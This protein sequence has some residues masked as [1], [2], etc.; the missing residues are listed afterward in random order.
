MP[1]SRR[2]ACVAFIALT[3]CLA[4]LADAV[5]A[6]PVTGRPIAELLRDAAG[7]GLRIVFSDELVP[8][9]LLAVSEPVSTETVA[10]LREILRPHALT[11]LEVSPGT[12]VVTRERQEPRTNAARP[13]P[14]T[15]A[16]LEEVHVISSRFTLEA[17]R[18][19]DAFV[20]NPVDLEQQPALFD[21]PVRGVRRF[22]GTAGSGLSSRSFVRGGTPDENLLLLDGVAL[23]DPFHLPGLPADFSV[24]DP[25]VLGRVDFYSGVLPV[26][27]GDRASSVIDMRS[28]MSADEFAGR[29]A[30]STLNVSTLAEG[31][32]PGARGDW[33]AFARRGTVDLVAG[34]L[35]PDFG[36]PV[37]TDALGRIRYRLTSES[38]LTLGGLGADDDLRLSMRDGAEVTS[39]DSDRGYS[40]VALDQQFGAATARTLLT[41]TSS[42]VN[43][44]GDLDDPVGSTGGVRDQR[45]LQVSVLKQ[46]WTTPLTPDRAL[47]W[48]AS[49]RRDRA[50]YDY[51]RM[52][53]FPAEIAALFDRP[54]VSQYAVT[55][56]ASLRQYAAYAGMSET[57]S[58]RWRVDGGVRWTLAEYSTGQEESAWDPRIGLM[59]HYSP[60]TRLRLSWGKMTQIWGA[61]EVPVE[62]DQALF[63][64]SSPSYMSVLGWEHDFSSGTT[65]RA[66]LYDKRVR[67]PRPRLENMLDPVVLVPEL[68]PDEVLIE[69]DWSRVTGLD[70]HATAALGR[71]SNG[72]LSYSW[73]HARDVIDGREVARSWDQRHAL[74]LGVATE[75][76]GWQ[77]SSLLTLRTDWPLTPVFE[78][79][80]PPGVTI[81][82][83]NS[84][85]DGFFMTLDLKAE[86]TF[87]LAIGSLHVAAELTNALDRQNFCCTE[88]EFE[89]APDG[90]L[91]AEESRKYWLPTV[92]YV[93]VAWEF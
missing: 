87:R 49:I 51:A 61:D 2:P 45:R 53:S 85:R 57:L 21:D 13:I 80:S 32:L 14:R 11:L 40:W 92:P 54:P 56:A 8:Q 38:T 9:D 79:S 31:P 62:R 43:R 37:L 82:E 25:V 52:T 86:R 5:A 10:Q 39:I 88:L 75:R 83:R 42:S 63:D 74:A 41:H 58:S 50:E 6:V 3:L 66:E 26:E 72:W 30:L 81:G 73:S 18:A 64:R 91:T 90:A 35:E 20:L 27:Y 1:T 36:R 93:S 33:L 89:T 78:S 77:F 24:I 23:H 12:Y 44:S 47:R 59:Y 34:A 17:Q 76:R 15:A 16:P 71:R 67:H 69:P 29:I 65:L 60:D 28:R 19:A 48:G 70:L 68:R 55:T 46:D 84:D 4:T 22:P 7:R